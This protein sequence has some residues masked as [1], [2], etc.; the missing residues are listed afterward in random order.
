[1][2]TGFNYRRVEHSYYPEVAEVQDSGNFGL[3][4]F[5][6]TVRRFM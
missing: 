3:E 1:M 5:R 2:A 6:G 4:S